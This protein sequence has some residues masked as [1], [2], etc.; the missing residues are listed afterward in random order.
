M[1]SKKVPAFSSFSKSTNDFFKKG[2]P[3]S[4]KLEL[5][6]QTEQ[7]LTFISTAEHKQRKDGTQYILGKLET[8]YK[9]EKFG[10]ECTGTVDTD[11]LLK[12]DFSVS[13]LGLPG[14]KAILKPQTG[15]AQEVT[16]GFEY[17]Q[18]HFSLSTT[19][20]WRPVGDI[21]VSAAAVGGLSSN[22]SLGLE[23]SYF[24]ARGVDSK[25]PPG[26]DSF[27]GL[28]N[29]KTDSLDC[30][31]YAKQQWNVESKEESKTGTQKL[32]VGGTYEHKTGDTVLQST[33][34][35][36]TSK[37]KADSITFQYGGSH[38]LDG[39][40]STQ[41]K[42]NTDGRLT[43]ILAKQFT[44]QLKGTLITDFNTVALGTEHKFAY[45]LSF[46]P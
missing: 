23:S 30:T 13:N 28:L 36:D 6:T 12:G 45:G 38:K 32:L 18:P 1:S 25:S 37:A 27:K 41:A 17:Q 11:N 7:G 2:F 22:V 44:P 15:P 39:T 26:L 40:T 16:A 4:H 21:L 5:S 31:L 46:K 14:F 24:V 3:E 35:W 10:L 19:V 20:L 9:L 8:K 34:E 42:I 43:V 29:Y 33:M